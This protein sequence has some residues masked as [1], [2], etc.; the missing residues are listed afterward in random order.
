MTVEKMLA[1]QRQCRNP[2]LMK[3]LRE[4]RYAF[5]AGKGYSWVVVPALAR[6]GV[7]PRF[8]HDDYRFRVILPCQ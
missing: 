4:Y 6:H 1:G 5:Y 8:E 3:I 2:F 7:V